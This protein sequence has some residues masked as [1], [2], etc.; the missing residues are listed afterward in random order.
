MA[1]PLLQCIRDE[2]KKNV[3]H[4]QQ[5]ML[6]GIS[7]QTERQATFCYRCPSLKDTSQLL[8]LFLLNLPTYPHTHTHTRA[9]ETRGCNQ[10]NVLANLLCSSN[11]K[12][13]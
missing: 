5:G 10:G 11:P 8:F 2:H 12:G 3:A 7:S 6:T 13:G 9:L 1:R 4:A